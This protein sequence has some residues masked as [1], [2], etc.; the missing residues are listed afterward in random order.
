MKSN[1]RECPHNNVILVGRI[2]LLYLIYVDNM[3]FSNVFLNMWRHF[4]SHISYF[5][6]REG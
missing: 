4:Y 6:K 1:Q 2:A 3:L 5:V